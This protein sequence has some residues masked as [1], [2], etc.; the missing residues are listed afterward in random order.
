MPPRSPGRPKATDPRAIKVT[1]RLTE[2]EAD[3]LLRAAR[4]DTLSSALRKALAHYLGLLGGTATLRDTE[5]ALIRRELRKAQRVA[6]P[7]ADA[8][9]QVFGLDATPAEDAPALIRPQ[10]RY[11]ETETVPIEIRDASGRVIAR[12]TQIQAKR[13]PTS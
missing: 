2:R 9:E 11:A 8:L 1:V 10:I 4:D 3:M 5:R 13:P 7:E 6:S 12:G